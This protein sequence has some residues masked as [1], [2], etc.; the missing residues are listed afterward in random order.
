MQRTSN[1]KP[2]VHNEAHKRCVYQREDA[3]RVRNS[4]KS[5]PKTLAGSY[6]SATKRNEFWGERGGGVQATKTKLESGKRENISESH[7]FAVRG[8]RYVNFV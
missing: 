1:V 3:E 2:T 5:P 6:T 7:I 8:S 4:G